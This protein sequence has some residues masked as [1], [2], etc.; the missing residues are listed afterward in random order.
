[1]FGGI[2]VLLTGLSY[3]PITLLAP[4]SAVTPEIVQ[5]QLPDLPE[6]S[7]DW[8]TN[9]ATAVGAVGY[10]GV[11]AST[12]TDG[13]RPI[14]S[15]TK[16]I[17]ALVVL[18]KHPLPADAA[19]PSI[20]FSRQD[21]R[22][23][24]DYLSVGGMVKPVRAGLSLTQRELLEVV[25]IPSANNYA[26][27]LVLWAFGTEAAFLD[28]ARSWLDAHGLTN[29]AIYEPTGMDP[30]NVSTAAELLELAKIA[31]ADQTVSAIVAKPSAELP[32]IGTVKNSNELL[33]TLGIDGIKTGTIDA[34]G[35]CLLF[36]ADFDI[37]GETVTVVG[38]ALG[39]VDH[40][41]QF[42]QVTG[43]MA[44]VAANFRNVPFIKP[45]DV[46]AS[47]T[48]AWGDSAQA[49][50]AVGYSQLVWGAPTVSIRVDAAPV[51]IA[52]EGDGLGSVRISVNGTVTE[53]PLELKGAI[54]DPGPEWRLAN[55]FSL[56]G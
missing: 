32:Y 39:G 5:Y 31:I 50:A 26:K 56:N 49:V 54:D 7:L 23:Y 45:G 1:M 43:L 20:S 40:D 25:L 37:G 18:E 14:A 15:I 36:S 35:A 53:V 22:Y 44:S 3:L 21:V 41:T 28:A 27:S 38:V 42:P 34:A 48:T 2:A 33:G 55:P 11:L 47:Y 46:L 12:G 10:P 9:A 8:P 29:T 52:T 19:G 16:I 6:P 17:T 51:A 30:R 13:P 24:D 4:V